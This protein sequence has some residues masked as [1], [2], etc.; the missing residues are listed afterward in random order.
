MAITNNNVPCLHRKEW[1]TMNQFITSSSAGALV[2]TDVK[3]RKDYAMVFAASQFIYSHNEDSIMLL[4]T[5]SLAGT[6]GAG[7]CGTT[8]RWSSTITTN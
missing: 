5:A 1:Q 8:I 4:N 3:E 7:T 2:T 6:F